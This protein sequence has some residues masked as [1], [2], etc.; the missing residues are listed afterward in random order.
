MAQPTLVIRISNTLAQVSDVADA[1]ARF[2]REQ[3]LAQKIINETNV[4][5]DEILSN[6]IRHGYRQRA[7]G[8]IEVTL[9]RLEHELHVT[10]EDDGIPFDL[11]RH[12]LKA[13]T[14]DKP[15]T[16][17]GGLGLHFVRAL[18]TN[19]SYARV[20]ACN[21]VTFT[22][23]LSEGQVAPEDVGFKLRESLYAGLAVV[24]VEGRLGSV[25]ATTL[26]NHL[27]TRIAEGHIRLIVDLAAV[28]TIASGGFWAFLTILKATELKRGRLILSGVT[29]EIARFFEIAGLTHTFE[30]RANPEA[31]IAALSEPRT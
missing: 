18:T 21:R 7:R 15:V 11:T 26:K 19:L 3:H 31:A 13:F 4:V 1:A 27:Q 9:R 22:K 20:G 25:N 17:A 14:P 30:A 24:S 10:I 5:L 12:V 28:T 16:E 23:V 6:T 29:A 2:G 8:Q